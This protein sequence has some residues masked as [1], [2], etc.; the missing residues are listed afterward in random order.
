MEIEHNTI[1]ITD[2]TTAVDLKAAFSISSAYKIESVRFRN[3]NIIKEGTNENACMASIGSATVASNKHTDIIIDGNDC[4]G[5]CYGTYITTNATNGLGRITHTNNRI[6]DLADTAAFTETAGIIVNL[7]G[8][9]TIDSLTLGGNDYKGT[10]GEPFDRGTYLYAGTIT[11]LHYRGDTHETMAI[12]NY[13]EGACT[14]TNK[15]GTFPMLAY[16]AVWKAGSTA[17]T[18]GNGTQNGY[19]KKSGDLCTVTGKLV[20]GSTSAFP[21]SGTINVSLPITAATS[22]VKYIGDFTVIDSGTTRYQGQFVI[23]GTGTVGAFER[24]GGTFLTDTSPIALGNT[25]ELYFNVT[26]RVAD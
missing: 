18:V 22:G 24:D 17:I 14:I 19:Y 3:N 11:D 12:A 15:H 10:V 6:K 25:D 9:N 21:G 7:V 16:T 4:K 2:D 20:L 13:D 5:T 26:Y 23:D 8:T 1:E